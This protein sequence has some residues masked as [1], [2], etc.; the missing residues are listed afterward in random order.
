MLVVS[1]II[2]WIL[3][4]ILCIVVIALTRQ[5]GLLHERIAPAGALAMSKG[6]KVGAQLPALSLETLSGKPMD[7]SVGQSSGKS[8]LFFFL[9]TTCPVCKTLLPVLKSSQN[10]ESKW[11]DIIL[12]SDGKLEEHKKLVAKEKLEQFPYIV[13]EEFGR[14]LQIG[15]LPYV[16][17]ANSE[18]QIR[19]HGLV[20]SR[21]H[22]E[23]I[24]EAHERG[25]ES[26]QEYLEQQGVEAA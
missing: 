23:S 19:A 10:A 18:G 25:V 6:P 1:N 2:L 5:I 24:F 15:K 17:L 13:S 11:L 12:T 9:S 8:R 26:I 22:I 21:E 16:V 4:V 3:V 14:E 7:L 20:N